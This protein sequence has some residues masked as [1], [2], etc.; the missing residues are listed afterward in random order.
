LV[1]GRK[2]QASPTCISYDQIMNQQVKR[3]RKRFPED[4]IFQLATEEKEEV[5][6]KCDCPKTLKLP[7]FTDLPPGTPVNIRLE[8]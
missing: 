4:F 8:K 5:V 2:Q 1:N 6:A 7:C 3:N